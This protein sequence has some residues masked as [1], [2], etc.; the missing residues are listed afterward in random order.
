[1]FFSSFPNIS[2]HLIPEMTLESFTRLDTILLSLCNYPN[3][4]YI[5][6]LFAVLYFS[7]ANCVCSVFLVVLFY[8]QFRRSKEILKVKNLVKILSKDD[9]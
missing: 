7:N 2:N 4:F 8:I 5:K 9:S 3:K 6:Y 1:M